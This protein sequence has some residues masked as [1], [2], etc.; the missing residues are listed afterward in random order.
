MIMFYAVLFSNLKQ[1]WLVEIVDAGRLSEAEALMFFL[2]P[3]I[4][5]LNLNTLWMNEA[6]LS[7]VVSSS[8]IIRMLYPSLCYGKQDD[9]SIILMLNIALKVWTCCAFA[10]ESSLFPRVL[11]SMS[12]LYPYPLFYAPRLFNHLQWSSHPFGWF[13]HF[14]PFADLVLFSLDVILSWN[15]IHKS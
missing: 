7:V 1:F 13:W 3:L 10:K 4:L 8:P 14:Y 9:C 12:F 15:K 6:K 5:D 11:L 2:P